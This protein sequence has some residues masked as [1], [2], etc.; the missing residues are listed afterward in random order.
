MPLFKKKK[1]WIEMNID[2]LF[3]ESQTDRYFL[4]LKAVAKHQNESVSITIGNL[5]EES[6]LYSLT[7]KNDNTRQLFNK[8][9]IKIKKIRILK[10]VNSNDSSEC[11]LKVGFMTKTIT[12]STVEAVRMALEHSH[13]I[14]VPREMIKAE[15][16]DLTER[17][18]N[19]K[20][21]NNIFATK[22]IERDSFNSNE[23]IM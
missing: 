9:G 8:I 12:L 5:F 15:Q 14:E 2:K 16:I 23:V 1:E 6:V 18:L 20:F 4:I 22:F 3:F 19:S 11:V 10:K 21:E 17:A 13:P 7:V